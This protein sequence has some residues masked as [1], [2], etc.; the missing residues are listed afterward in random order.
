[1]SE[2]CQEICYNHPNQ[3]RQGCSKHHLAFNP[4]E[5]GNHAIWTRGGQMIAYWGRLRQSRGRLLLLQTAYQ[6]TMPPLS[7]QEIKDRA[8]AFVKDW[9]GV[10]RERAEA[11]TFW[12]EFFAIFGMTRRRVAAFEEPVKKLG[13]RRGAIDLFWKGTLL[14][15]HKSKGKDLGKAYEQAL[16]YFPG[17]QEQDLPQYV[18]VSDFTDF[19]LYDLDAGIET[20]F[21]LADLPE[22]VHLFGFISGYTPHTYHDED[23]VNIQVAEKMGELHDELLASGYDGHDLELFLVRLIYCLFADDTGIFPR[24]HFHYF[25]ENRTN[26]NGSDTGPILATIFQTLNRPPERRQRAIDEELQQFPYIN[27]QLFDENLP[28]PLFSAKMR[29]QLLACCGF[30]WGKVSPA[31]FGSMFQAVMDKAKR[32]NLGAHY[33]SEKNI[34]KVVRG[35]FL[36]DL[37]QEFE[38]AK[39]D[40]NKLRQLH[41]RIA[42]LRFFDPAC[43]CGNF[44]IITY[45]ELRKLEIAIL[46]QLHHLSGEAARQLVMDVRALSKIDVDAMYGIELEEFPARIA[47]VALWLTDHQ[48]NM[49]LSREFGQTFVRLPLQKSAHIHHGNALRLDWETIIP[50]LDGSEQVTLYILGNPPFVGK[51]LRT[52]A[53]NADMELACASLPE[54][55]MLDYV[56][57]WYVKAAQFIQGTASRVAFVSTNSITQGEQVGALW[58]WLLAQGVKI[59]FAH[60]TFRWSNDARGKAAVFCVIIGFGLQEAKTKRLY[61]YLTPDA[62]P[63]EALVHNI[64]PYLVATD[65]TIIF[66]RKKPICSVPE[67]GYGS[68]ANDGGFLIL[69][70]QQRDDLL[71]KEPQAEKYIRPFL[72]SREFINSEKRWCLWLVNASP[73]ELR[74]MPEIMHR[75]KGVRQYR[76]ESKREATRKLAQTPYLFGEIRQP[77]SHYLLIPGVSSETRRYIPIGFMGKETIAS[78]LARTLPD[79]TPYHFGVLTSTMHMAWTRQVCGRL[80]GDYRYSNNIVYNNFPWPE[81]PTPAHKQR[82]E[83]AAQTVLDARAQFPASTLADLYDPNTMP[84]ALFDAHRKLDLAVDACYR[85]K[86]FGSELERLAFLFEL[87]KHYTEPLTHSAEQTAKKKRKAKI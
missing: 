1:M 30:D 62:D 27:G 58:Q 11:Q 68:M 6:N 73:A 71:A 3:K 80:K 69:D 24:D 43:G 34:L 5:P 8:Y 72:G 53:Q 64:S 61:E 38:R 2:A 48:M 23:P 49:Q 44:L 33:T 79:A 41:E 52:A 74:K 15:E 66:S 59:H 12:N 37:L 26:P 13:E 78:D 84:K 46:K 47:E 31:I 60:R 75:V 87:Y 7:Q 40:A 55:G 67:I 86:A 4:A 18:L 85:S 21:A 42:R 10:S 35:L 22:K 28:I 39:S 54:H 57:A 25:I 20:D 19:R 70:Q 56:S 29:T 14:V 63:M 17:I 50:K 83:A 77:D 16:D 45:R 81:N 9:E 51:H 32:R 36:D 76:L 82:V 65:N